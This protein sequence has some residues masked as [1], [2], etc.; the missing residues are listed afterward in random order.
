MYY[1]YFFLKMGKNK[2]VILIEVLYFI[3]LCIELRIYF[4]YGIELNNNLNMVKIVYIKFI[5]KLNVIY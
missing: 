3:I 1:L 2:L 5:I 4:I